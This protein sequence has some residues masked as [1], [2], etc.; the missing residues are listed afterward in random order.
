M[1][2]PAAEAELSQW[3]CAAYLFYFLMPTQTTS[4]FIVLFANGNVD[5]DGDGDCDVSVGSRIFDIGL[6]LSDSVPAK[7]SQ[8]LATLADTLT[9]T[10][11]HILR[12]TL[13]IIV[14]VYFVCA[15]IFFLAL[16]RWQRDVCATCGKYNAS[17][18][19]CLGC[20]CCLTHST[21]IIYAQTLPT[22]LTNATKSPGC[23]FICLR[24]AV[25][26]SF[27]L[28]KRGRGG[29][30]ALPVSELSLTAHSGMHTHTHTGTHACTCGKC[31][32]IRRTTKNKE[33][34]KWRKGAFEAF[35]N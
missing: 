23:L 3:E 8:W 4:I 21:H 9:H 2:L 16:W 26:L 30:K 15:L 31:N 25:F 29:H 24:R 34:R 27:C 14:H 13:R 33:C 1:T 18:G 32:G 12:Q 35:S 6:V 20:C 22:L 10:H 28:V 19:C 11:A 5:G 17:L 7:T